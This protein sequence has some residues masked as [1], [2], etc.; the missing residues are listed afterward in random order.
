[1]LEIHLN[2]TYTKSNT[3]NILYSID[4]NRDNYKANNITCSVLLG[5]D[6]FKVGEAIIS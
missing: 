4:G 5:N 1:M 2:I 3:Y 6:P